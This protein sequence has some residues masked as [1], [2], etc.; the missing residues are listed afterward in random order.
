M[1]IPLLR[2]SGLCFRHALAQSL[3]EGV[4]LEL[5]AGERIGIVGANGCGKSTLLQ[6]LL[7]LLPAQGGTIEFF[8]RVQR[9]ETDF[10]E[11]RGRVGLLFQD[12]DDQLFCPT[13]EEDVAF[14]PLNQ[15]HRLDQARA[16][17]AETLARLRLEHLRT[18]PTHHLSG[19][20]KRLVGLAG[21]LAMRPEVLL[22]DEPSTGLDEAALARVIDI[23]RELPQ[24]MLVVS[25]DRG[26]LQQVTTS[27]K[28]LRE[29]TLQGFPAPAR[30]L[31][32]V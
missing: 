11:I 1:S 27:V 18:R 13:V 10:R 24:A 22:L 31:S 14:G 25:H 21:L 6:L 7:G 2:L 20:E 4:D 15:G 12:A 23:L 16:I 28:L 30:R 26:F 8:G 9:K 32:A 29:G 19:G 17:V 5:C 3:L